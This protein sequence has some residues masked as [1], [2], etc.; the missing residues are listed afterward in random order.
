MQTFDELIV[1]VDGIRKGP[2]I[3]LEPT[4]SFVKYT[5]SLA[6]HFSSDAIFRNRYA[7]SNSSGRFRV[8]GPSLLHMEI[9]KGNNERL[10]GT[11]VINERLVASGSKSR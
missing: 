10:Y 6:V 4:S 7:R 5:D 1:E 8:G 3:R 9:F 2:G 11:S